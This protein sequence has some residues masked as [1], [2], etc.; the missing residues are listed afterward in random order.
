MH[1]NMARCM[2][3]CVVFIHTNMRHAGHFFIAKPQKPPPA[4]LHPAGAATVARHCAFSAHLFSSHGACALPLQ[5]AAFACRGCNFRNR[6]H[7]PWRYRTLPSHAPAFAVWHVKIHFKV[8]AG[9]A[10]ARCRLRFEMNAFR[11]CPILRGQ[12]KPVQ[13]PTV[14]NHTAFCPIPPGPAPAP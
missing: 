13:A 3:P 8:Q 6:Q 14:V 12:T 1:T 9:A 7:P 2:Q 5:R 4:R 11:P 10:I